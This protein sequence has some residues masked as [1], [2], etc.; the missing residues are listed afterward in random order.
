MPVER[1]SATIALVPLA[2]SL[3]L[4]VLDDIV[5]LFALALPVVWTGLIWTKVTYLSKLGHGS[6]LVCLLLLT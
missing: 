5:L 4:A 3:G 6:L 1:R 2:T